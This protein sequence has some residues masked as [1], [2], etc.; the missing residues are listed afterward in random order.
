M[1]DTQAV[2]VWSGFAQEFFP[3]EP[4]SYK[5]YRLNISASYGSSVNTIVQIV[6]F[7]LLQVQAVAQSCATAVGSGSTPAEADADA[8]VKATIEANKLLDCKAVWSSTVSY[9][10]RCT[11]IGALGTEVT[12]ESTKTSLISFN[13]AHTQAYEEAKAAAEEELDC[14]GDNSEQQIAIKDFASGDMAKAAPYPSVKYVTGGPASITKVVVHING[15]THGSPDDVHIALR[16]PEGTVVELMR[17]SG[18]SPP[19]AGASVSNL[20]LVFDSDEATTL[21]DGAPLV[22]DTYNPTPAN[23]AFAPYPSPLGTYVILTPGSPP[24]LDGSTPY[25]T[26]LGAFATE[27][28]NGSWSLWVCDDLTFFTGSI[29][30]WDLT[31]T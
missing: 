14:T 13:D 19:T 21:P 29:K 22:S 31:I 20:D 24:V 27:D 1:L 30:S 6:S 12:R 16:S 3:A 7:E 8:I 2:P 4:A 9:T 17:N 25:G 18:G 15:F 5:Q 10:A 11:D 23:G 28:A 26:D